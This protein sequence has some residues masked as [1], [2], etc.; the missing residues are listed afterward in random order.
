MTEESTGADE[1]LRK[2][3]KEVPELLRA[4]KKLLHHP[5]R[6][7]VASARGKKPRKADQTG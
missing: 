3:N 7:G 4:V 6:R 5:P 1:V 2:S